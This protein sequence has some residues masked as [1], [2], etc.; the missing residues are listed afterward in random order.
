MITF[1]MKNEA[2]SIDSTYG[3]NGIEQINFGFFPSYFSDMEFQED[4]K[5]LM[6]SYNLQVIDPIM[7]TRRLPN[8]T[9]D[10]GF[11]LNG[12]VRTTFG[13]QYCDTYEIEQLSDGGILIAG[14]ADGNSAMLKL[15]ENGSID[16]TFGTNGRVIYSFGPSVGSRIRSLE[17]D[18][19]ERIIAIG[20]A[21][22]YD[23][24]S[25]DMAVVRFNSN[26]SVDSSFGTSG[27]TKIDIQGHNDLASCSALL[28]DGKILIAGNGR[29]NEDNTN[30][31]M[32]RLNPDGT[33]DLSFGNA[34][35]VIRIINSDYNETFENLH[36]LDDQSILAVGTSAGDFAILKFNPSGNSIQSFG[37]QG[38][39]TI[40]FDDYQD[41]GFEI[42]VDNENRILLGG[43]GSD[44]AVGGLFHAALVRLTP[45]GQMD[46]SFGTNGKWINTLGQTGSEI[47]AMQWLPDGKLQI[48]GSN[49]PLNQSDVQ[50]FL[51]RIIIENTTKIA[52]LNVDEI[53]IFPNPTND[54]IHVSNALINEPFTIYDIN[55]KC[56]LAGTIENSKIIVDQLPI[57]TYLLRRNSVKNSNLQKFILIR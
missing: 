23:N 53:G 34:G 2:Q 13:F 51:A 8:G 35:K 41:N 32:T 28:P 43:Y 52:D 38:Y 11:G 44:V 17:I 4:G 14:M 30:F 50:P 6:L 9:V 54:V 29:D 3:I 31:A 46:A 36:I 33:I 47:Y 12:Q 5:I 15:T 24:L 55:G 20:E 22:N 37:N 21:Y 25:F 56:V 48:A 26:G 16:S 27:N 45:D 49:I 10:N 42:L 7:I 19:N 1:V 40:D 39:T 18:Q 57:G